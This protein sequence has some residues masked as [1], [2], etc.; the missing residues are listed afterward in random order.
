M[1]IHLIADLEANKERFIRRV[2]ESLQV[3][4]LGSDEEGARCASHDSDRPVM[5]FWSDEAYARQHIRQQWGWQ[6]FRPHLVE[7]E[8]FLVAWLPGLQ[9]DG[10]LVGLNYNSD[11]AG[12]E[13]EPMEVHKELM[14][15]L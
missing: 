3:W 15:R 14:E 7:L 12:L 2:L 1:K 10:M 13:L 4:A 5:L 9:Q 8:D 6:G 11:L